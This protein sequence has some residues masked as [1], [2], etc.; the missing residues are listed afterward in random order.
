M[1]EPISDN[2]RARDSASLPEGSQPTSWEEI[3]RHK[4]GREADLPSGQRG[5]F[6]PAEADLAST[7]ERL[8]PHL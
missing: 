1:E 7:I 5:A 3:G 6:D 4:R 8:P 2:R